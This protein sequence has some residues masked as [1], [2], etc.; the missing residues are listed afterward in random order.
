MLCRSSVIKYV[1]VSLE[2]GKGKGQG[3][4]WREGGRRGREGGGKK[5]GR[6][7]EEGGR[8]SNHPLCT[9]VQLTVGEGAS[10][11][12]IVET[13]DEKMTTFRKL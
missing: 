11:D 8:G 4:H 7:G 2:G 10:F 13:S 3:L 5:G 12:S 9:V 1:L 6:G